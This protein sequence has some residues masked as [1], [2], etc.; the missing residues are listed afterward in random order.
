M[1]KGKR[2]TLAVF[3]TAMA[4]FMMFG[5]GYGIY[6]REEGKELQ[7][8]AG[9]GGEMFLGDGGEGNGISLTQTLIERNAYDEYGIS[10]TAMTAIEVKAVV[11]PP[12]AENNRLD[13]S[14]AW[15]SGTGGAWGEGKTVTDY[16]TGRASQDTLTYTL[17]CSQAFGETI[18][19]RAEIRGNSKIFKTKDVEFLQGYKD[20]SATVVHDDTYQAG[21]GLDW[22]FTGETSAVDF[23]GFPKTTETF[24]DY[25][26]EGGDGTTTFTVTTGLTDVYTVPATVGDVKAEVSASQEYLTAATSAYGTIEEEADQYITLGESSGQ[27]AT[28]ETFI[29]KILFLTDPGELEYAPFKYN[30]SLLDKP[31]L[32]LKLT[33]TVNG[34][35]HTQEIGIKFNAGSFGTFASGLEWENED[36]IVF[37]AE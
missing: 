2:I 13:W 22:K 34:H 26:A 23:A 8:E 11:T 7:S 4:M 24:K 9:L 19:L 5:I 18:V 31:L 32:T 33:T 6:S 15:T 36:E 30:L 27:D 35:V 25:Y 21:A 37:S 28:I 17:E 3:S 16:V 20:L 29:A 12:E 14:L 1:T 10:P